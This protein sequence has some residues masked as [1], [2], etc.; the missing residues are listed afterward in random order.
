[1]A[2]DAARDALEQRF[3]EQL[4]DDESLRA[5]LTDDEYQP[6]QDWALDRLHER[7]CALADPAASDAETAMASILETLRQVL[8]AVDEAVGHRADRDAQAFAEGLAPLVEAI[9]PPLYA[10]EG[11][12]TEVRKNVEALIPRLAAQKDDLDGPALVEELVTA[13]AGPG[14]TASAAHDGEVGAG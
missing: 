12:A 6:L 1:M 11:P 3:A 9:A 5:D 10:V 14:G 13:L 4:L 7:A 8:R 2:D